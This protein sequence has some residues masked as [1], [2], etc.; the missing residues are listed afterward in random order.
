MNTWREQRGWAGWLALLVIGLAML[1][2]TVSRALAP[3]DGTMPPGWVEVCTVSG[4]RWVQLDAAG[5]IKNEGS[6]GAPVLDHCPL[7]LLA[8]DRLAP[9]PTP[10]DTAAALRAD[11]TQR[12]AAYSDPLACA[13][14][15]ALAGR[16]RGPPPH[17]VSF[18]VA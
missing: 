13:A 11:L 10:L 3:R 2:P 8:G 7:C 9:P 16:P 12:L 1:A 5:N 6:P 4:I 15:P 14:A 18:I 17:L